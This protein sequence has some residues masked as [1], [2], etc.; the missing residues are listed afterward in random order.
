[1]DAVLK[2]LLEV[3]HNPLLPLSLWEDR[4]ST[5]HNVLPDPVTAAL[6]SIIQTFVAS[7]SDAELPFDQPPTHFSSSPYTSAD[8]S[9][10]PVAT[11]TPGVDFPA[12]ELLRAMDEGLAAAPI[13]EQP[14]LEGALAGLRQVASDHEAGPTAFARAIAHRI[15]DHFLA[16]EAPFLVDSVHSSDADV[17][18]NLRRGN[19]DNL[20][21]VS[22]L[23]L[24][25]W[26][27][28]CQYIIACL[29]SFGA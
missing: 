11:S 7:V 5:V 6:S 26:H 15:L 12:A 16:S 17:I 9:R 24:R 13:A 18:D 2:Q 19:A 3:A 21:Q 29:H 23:R 25:A 22:S 28:T 1:V 8:A 10:A 14:A 4:W 20:Q 27:T